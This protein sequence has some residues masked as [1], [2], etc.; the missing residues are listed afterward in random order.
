MR[1][2]ALVACSSAYLF[3]SVRAA[4]VLP[5]AAG[6]PNL[7]AESLAENIRPAVGEK[8]QREFGCSVSGVKLHPMPRRADDPQGLFRFIVSTR[9]L[10]DCVLAVLLDEQ[11]GE[12]AA[13]SIERSFVT[14]EEEVRNKHH[15]VLRNL[16][17]GQ[18]LSYL[19]GDITPQVGN[20]AGAPFVIREGGGEAESPTGL[21]LSL[22]W[23]CRRMSGATAA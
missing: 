23:F 11:T 5:S 4:S 21:M 18:T 14:T 9:E 3:P 22:G 16:T 10:S 12:V 1:L 8:L 7:Q 15:V 2:G 13:M 19:R 20:Y 6:V 17:T